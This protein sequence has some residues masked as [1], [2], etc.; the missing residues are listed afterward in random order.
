MKRALLIMIAAVAFVA[1]DKSKGAE[2]AETEV[3]ATQTANAEEQPA[4]ETDDGDELAEREAAEAKAEKKGG[5][6]DD[7]E[8]GQTGTYGGEFT[9][10]EAPITLAKAIEQAAGHEGPVKVEAT[11]AKVCKKKGC[12]FTMADDSTDE[13]IRVKMKDYGFF[14][15]RNADGAKVVAEGVIASREI[16]QEEAQHYADDAAEAGEEPKKV[17]GPQKVW[18]FT[19]TAVEVRASEG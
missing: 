16:P 6:A 15:P 1:C 10:S 9:V 13:E 18:E 12:W 19:A 3:P 17:E 4:A 8:P 5:L 7:L 14:V 11:V 2:Q